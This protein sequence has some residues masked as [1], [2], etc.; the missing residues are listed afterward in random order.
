MTFSSKVKEELSYINIFGNKRLVELEFIGY[1]NSI[2]AKVERKKIYYSTNNE[3]NINRFGKLLKILGIDFDISIVGQKYKI[4]SK[5]INLQDYINVYEEELNEIEEKS[6]LR[7]IY[8]G[9]GLI[10]EPKTYYSIEFKIKNIKFTQKCIGILQKRDLK[11]NVYTMDNY[12][13]IISKDGEE[14]SKFLAFIGANKSVLEYE[15]I[16][17]LKDVRNNINRQVNCETA[18]L[19]KTVGAAQK[20][21]MA[22]NNIKQKGV[23]N[24]LTENQREIAD[25]RIKYPELTLIE[26]GRKL[27]KPLGKSGVNNRLK[28]IM[29]LNEELKENDKKKNLGMYIHIP[30]C[31]SKCSYCD[32][33][34]YSNIEEKIEEY[35]KTLIEEIKLI[36]NCNKTDFK[37]GVDDL[38]FLDTIYIGGGTP[39]YIEANYIEKIMKTIKENINIEKNAEIT[40]EVNPGTVDK[41]K[42]SK[43]YESGINRVSIGLQSTNDILLKQINRIHTFV[44]FEKTFELARSVGFKNI[45]VDLMIGLP[46]QTIID[47]EES[48]EKIIKLN[49]EHIS[50]YSLILEEGTKLKEQIDNK[51]FEMIDELI[52]RQMYDLVVYKLKEAG[53]NHY[54]ISNFSKENKESKHNQ[55]CWNQKEYIGIG[56]SAHSYTNKIRYSNIDDIDKYIENF[57]NKKDE[58]NLIFHEKQDKEAQMKEYIIL[59]FRKIKGINKKE[60]K[61]KFEIELENYYKEELEVLIKQE[62][63]Q[64]NKE[65]ISLTKKG[66]DFANIVWGKFI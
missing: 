50:M 49:P 6:L 52:E 18:N 66:I 45:N 41:L 32:F 29:K 46:N 8:L 22:I 5:A 28:G 1:I 39:S 25:I 54:E 62:L 7:G 15:D 48:L 23:Y 14:I 27:N 16:R 57:K 58:D 20:Q 53:Y 13:T 11:F 59:G 10:N 12:Y 40:I 38:I 61:E 31:K 35:I 63:I 3:Y 19:D 30:F 56:V 9:G 65:T 34:S 43:Y 37:N 2:N 64:N 47:V 21:I 42:L 33:K 44:E 60:F 26:L 51:E 4:V 17:V 24:K 36:A 55:N